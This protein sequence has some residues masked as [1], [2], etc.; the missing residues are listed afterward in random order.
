MAKIYRLT[1]IT[2]RGENWWL[3][4]LDKLRIYIRGRH[5]TYEGS[6]QSQH[7]GVRKYLGDDKELLI[8]IFVLLKIEFPK[9][10]GGV[11]ENGKE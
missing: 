8:S 9:L 1:V 10:R 6:K 2:P 5:I 11:E 3:N 4:M 7:I